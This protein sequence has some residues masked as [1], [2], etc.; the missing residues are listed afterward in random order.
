VRLLSFVLLIYL[1][2]VGQSQ[3][4]SMQSIDS[5]QQLLPNTYDSARV[6]AL[7]QLAELHYNIDM[8]QSL[9]FGQTALDLAKQLSYYQGIRDAHRIL[10]RIHRRLGNYN[11][12][13]EYTLQ[14]LP[15]SERLRD[16][17]ELLD[18]Y[19]TLGNIY[20]SMA[21]F[22]EAQKHLRKAVA[23]GTSLNSP[24]LASILNFY[25]RAYGKI[26]NYDSAQYFIQ[27]ALLREMEKPQ[28]GYGLSYIYNNLAEVYY[29]TKQYEK[30]IE[31]YSLAEGLSEDKKSTYGKTFTLCGLALVYKD[32]KH[33][34]KALELVE[35]SIAIARENFFRDR[36]LEGYRIQYQIYQDRNDYKNALD[37]Y[38]LY[39]LYQD[40]IFSE[41][42]LQYI[43]NLKINYET[44]KMEQENK[45]LKTDTELKGSQLQQQY[46]LVWVAV[47]TILFL[48]TVSTLLYRN[49]KQRKQTNALLQEY[50]IDLKEQVDKRTQELVTSNL[51]LVKQNMQLEQY[52]YIIAHNLRGPVARILGLSNLITRSFDPKRDLEI[53]EQLHTSAEEL[54][55]VIHDLNIILDIKKG[56][57]HS[58]EELNLGDRVEKVKN[59]LHDKI[60]K[61]QANVNYDFSAAQTCYA[62]PAYIDSILY[63]LIHNG[64]KYRALD[65]PPKIFLRSTLENGKLLLTIQDN[66]M[67]IDLE[68]QKNKV[69]N[70][71]QRFHHHV[72]GKG[73]GLFLVKTQ[74]EALSGTILLES[75]V[76]KGTLIK[77]YLPLN[78]SPNQVIHKI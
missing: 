28:P 2:L 60:A 69:F 1:P 78:K 4:S 48:L 46:T 29:F 16:T 65:R 66:G 72:E 35:T 6:D 14:N 62:I 56:L 20:S 3:R 47:I 24:Q 45:L 21:N 27:H 61:T 26:G 54:D 25:G 76:N 74:V 53:I 15:I 75:E 63:N 40:S 22:G 13:I 64:I 33:F 70:L 5:L 32:L 11:V 31:F 43:E 9:R 52:G 68:K 34:N 17:L 10:R 73:L 49:N 50:S 58:Y 77:I 7:N 30:A 67:G 8:K 42:R 18:C 55:T 41:D 39:N 12:A 23:I 71:Y 57:Q 59:A 38:K 51:E 19:T 37:S 44:E 36:I